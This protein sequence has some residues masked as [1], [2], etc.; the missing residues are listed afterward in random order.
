MSSTGTWAAFPTK[1]IY[2]YKITQQ[3][4]N[5][6]FKTFSISEIEKAAIKTII[7]SK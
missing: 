3:K 2:L 4:Y 1:R 5:T 7:N 6:Y